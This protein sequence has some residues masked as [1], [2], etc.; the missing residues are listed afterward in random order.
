MLWQERASEFGPQG[1]INIF[2]PKILT[3]PFAFHGF[4]NAVDCVTF[5]AHRDSDS[6]VNP[7]HLAANG[8]R[9]SDVRGGRVS[10]QILGAE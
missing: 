6:L 8:C 10:G 5:V 1:F 9:F 2:G 4:A 3:E 7:R